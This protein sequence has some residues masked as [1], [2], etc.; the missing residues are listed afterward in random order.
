MESEVFL[1]RS[2]QLDRSRRP[3]TQEQSPQ[4]RTFSICGKANVK[5]SLCLTN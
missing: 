5:L 2:Q 1:L 4:P 3:E